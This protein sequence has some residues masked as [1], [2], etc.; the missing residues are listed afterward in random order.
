MAASGTNL[1]MGA[2]GMLEHHSHHEDTPFRDGRKPILFKNGKIYFTRQGERR[3]YF[4]LTLCMMVL[5]IGFKVGL[6]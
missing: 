2:Q 5:G 1:K 6:W 4:F 3:F